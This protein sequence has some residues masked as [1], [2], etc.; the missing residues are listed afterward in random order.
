MNMHENS[1]ANL[2]PFSKD[3]PPT[4]EQAKKAGSL[5]GK[6]QA[7]NKN[8]RKLMKEIYAEFAN[9]PVT[10]ELA[11]DLL[12]AVDQKKKKKIT[13]AESIVLAQIMMAQAGDT[14]AATFIR[15]TIGEKP[16]EH[17]AVA[18]IDP[19]VISEVEN[20]IHDEE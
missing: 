3:N 10:K 2:R 5:G 1:L 13:V 9:M 11:N 6:K 16:I 14:K 18:E 17:V 7:A 15:D 20:L 4:K 19:D 8:H 12:K